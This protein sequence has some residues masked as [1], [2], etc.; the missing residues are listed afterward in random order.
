MTALIK[1][2]PWPPEPWSFQ[3]I[4]TQ[5]RLFD[6]KGRDITTDQSARDR[7]LLCVNG[8]KGIWLAGDFVDE[9]KRIYTDAQEDRRKAW[10]KIDRLEWEVLGGK[11]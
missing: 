3:I 4:G 6:A 2:Q 5:W 1:N 9:A 10:E 11:A 7:M 8:F